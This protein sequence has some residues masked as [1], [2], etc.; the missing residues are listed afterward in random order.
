MSV[1]DKKVS[2]CT[3]VCLSLHLQL[4]FLNYFKMKKT[5]L[6]LTSML[7]VTVAHSQEK[8]DFK[9][10]FSHRTEIV[11][12][13]KIHYVIGGKGK[14]LVLLH[15]FPE[16]WY[17]WRHIM[18]ELAKQYTVIAPDMTGLGDSE[19]S[20]IGYDQHSV[21]MDILGLVNQLGYTKIN[22]VAHDLGVFIAYDYTVTNPDAVEKLAVLEVGIPDENMEKMPVISRKNKNLWWF[23]LHN[24]ADLPE[25]L[26][27]GNEKA[28]LSWFYNHSSF[29]SSVF[30]SKVIKEYTR[31]YSKTE[32]L[33]AALGYYRAIFKNIDLNKQYEN[34][35]I[36]I[37]VLAL[38]GDHSFGL[39]PMHSFQQR[40]TNVEGGIIENCG[41]FIAEEQPE[42]LTKLLLKFLNKE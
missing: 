24:V 38:G 26:I 2:T 30:T 18:P 32:V 34:K 19:S 5:W 21:A 39:Y 36:N 22:L 8:A 31:T 1:P 10:T 11:N 37:P 3:K 42:V 28:Y 15:G 17:T 40:A 6:L 25:I 16:T 20:T 13:H 27:K 9:K 23:A 33:K 35:K 14:P 7:L 29:N 41:H 12:G 4:K